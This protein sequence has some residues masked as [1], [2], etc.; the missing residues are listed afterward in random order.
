VVG[1]DALEF[2]VS[3]IEGNGALRLRLPAVVQVFNHQAGHLVVREIGN[4]PDNVIP[5]A[6]YKFES[7]EPLAIPHRGDLVSAVVVQR[8]LHRDV[9]EPR[10]VRVDPERQAIELA[11]ILAGEGARGGD[12]LRVVARGQFQLALKA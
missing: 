3:E 9:V 7:V 2:Q 12:A 6:V 11:P 8:D 1:I 5:F 4:L 10:K